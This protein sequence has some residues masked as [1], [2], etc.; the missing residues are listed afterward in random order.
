MKISKYLVALPLLSIF[1]V[2]SILLAP[3]ANAHPNRGMHATFDMRPGASCPSGSSG[4]QTAHWVYFTPRS[5]SNNWYFTVRE[6]TSSVTATMHFETYICANAGYSSVPQN[7]K[8]FW[9]ISSRINFGFGN[10]RGDRNGNNSPDKEVNEGRVSKPGTAHTTRSVTINTSGL[11]ARSSTYRLCFSWQGWG[12]YGVWVST[13]ASNTCIDVFVVK[14]PPPPPQYYVQHARWLGGT[15]LDTFYG[16]KPGTNITLRSD[17]ETEAPHRGNPPASTHRIKTNGSSYTNSRLTSSSTSS[18]RINN[19]PHYSSSPNRSRTYRIKRGLPVRHGNR[20]CFGASTTNWW[21]KSSPPPARIYQPGQRNIGRCYTIYNRRFGMR[22]PTVT[23]DDTAT[24]GGIFN[25]RFNACNDDLGE[26]TSQGYTGASRY[27]TPSGNRVRYV[28]S[29]DAELSRRSGSALN[30]QI[31][32]SFGSCETVDIDWNVS[33][34]ANIGE[35][36]CVRLTVI[37]VRGFSDGTG[38]SGTKTI[39]TCAGDEPVVSF[40]PYSVFNGSDIWAGGL[41][42]NTNTSGNLDTQSCNRTA[43]TTSS[44]PAMPEAVHAFVEGN[45]I[46]R[47]TKGGNVFLG[48]HSQYGTFALDEIFGFGSANFVSNSSSSGVT[49]PGKSA[50]RLSF[51]SAPF[52]NAGYYFGDPADVSSPRCINDLWGALEPH[53]V[54]PGIANAGA[55]VGSNRS[56]VF[57]MNNPDTIGQTGNSNTITVPAGSQ[58][59]LI[60]SAG[61][62]IHI[63]DNI[64]YENSGSGYSSAEDIPSLIIIGKNHNI[65][66]APE[67]TQLDGVYIATPRA[68][69]ASAGVFRTCQGSFYQSDVNSNNRTDNLQ[70]NNCDDDLSLNGAVVAR[71]VDLYRTGGRGHLHQLGASDGHQNTAQLKQNKFSAEIFDLNPEIYLSFPTFPDNTNASLRTQQIRDLPPVQ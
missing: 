57:L 58:K 27:S 3:S 29:A 15:T 71:R 31:N 33:N 61:D 17:V 53:A 30:G 46:V 4:I 26:V 36:L 63:K 43:Y 35:D 47:A 18:W 59:V 40:Q 5:G 68:S 6:G 41:F 48:A 20:I 16:P 67:V 9:N 62:R 55:L 56:G 1:F 50:Q 22:Q 69:Q 14:P 19:G 11:R 65:D 42:A 54:D 51:A 24:P 7:Y 12:D 64:V 70:L 2:L 60:A 25:T 49:G 39:S 34:T 45:H 44:P 23:N 8:D 28:V 32:R 10:E 66:I 37:N 21:G 13:P 52:A 38:M